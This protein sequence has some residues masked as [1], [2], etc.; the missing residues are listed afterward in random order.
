MSTEV[1]DDLSDLA[2]V[3][4]FSFGVF[5]K[6]GGRASHEFVF[7]RDPQVRSCGTCLQVAAHSTPL[8][9]G[10]SKGALWTETGKTETPCQCCARKLD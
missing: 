5:K 8:P 4:G 2:S 10:E 1:V 3:R 9:V 7:A 6:E